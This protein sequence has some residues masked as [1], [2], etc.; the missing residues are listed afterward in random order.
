MK[1]DEHMLLWSKAAVRILDIRYKV[2][3]EGQDMLSYRL[4]ANVFLLV[5]SGSAYVQIDE[6]KT[7]LKRYHLLHAGKGMYVDVMPAKHEFAC[8]LVFYKAV[9]PSTS[10]NSA[11][12]RLAEQDR[13]FG[14]FFHVIP[15]EPAM[16]YNQIRRMYEGWQQSGVLA[17]IRM[18]AMLFEFIYELFT[19]LETSKEM[20]S[21]SDLVTHAL[22]YIHEHYTKPVT[23]VQLA[24]LLGCSISYMHRLFKAE[25]GKS[26]NEYII[27]KRMEQAQQ[28]L[29]TTQLN[30]REIAESVG[31]SDV[32]Y[33]SRLYKK[34]FGISPLQARKFQSENGFSDVN[35]LNPSRSS[36]VPSLPHSYNHDVNENHFH[37]KGEVDLISNRNTKPSMTALLVL[38]LS[39]LMSACQSGGNSISS[40]NQGNHTSNAVNQAAANS[41]AK[42][43][44]SAP[45]TRLYKHKYGE[46][47]IP[48]QPKRIITPYHLGHM[49]ALGER[50]LGA[51][52]YVLQY[53]ASAMD[54]TG[55]A[56]L[57]APLN[58]E[59]I[60]DLE[61][62]LIIIIEAYLEPSGG[63]EAFSKIAPTVVLEAHQD[64]IKDITLIGDILGKQ[65]EAQQWITQ[66]EAKIAE[67]KERVHQVI[68]P[69]ETF[70]ILNVRTAKNRMIYR[71]RNMG[72]NILYTY[73]GFK[74]QEK[75]LKDVI[76]GIDDE[77]SY[78]DIAEEAIPEYAGD[79]LILAAAADAQD[80][81]DELMKSGIWKNLDAV[82]NNHV[83][84]IDF[85]QFLF[86]DP[87]FSMK[88]ID[89]LTDLLTAGQ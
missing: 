83:Y 33:F 37:Q 1:W 47:E 18:K 15:P 89:I 86:N 9:L 56:D 53:S 35:P 51:A 24:D 21:P 20:G 82:K 8:Y 81:V 31:Y 43:G 46:T 36:I 73:W 58:L 72:G 10:P 14:K 80:S 78:L 57:G 75:V 66:F 27:G 3:W 48:V 88:Q 28:Y 71:D 67:T 70:T 76:E 52:T 32:Y 42:D 63:Y 2:M 25:V 79:H 77:S 40:E 87:I 55:I 69:E 62:D 29:L 23:M 12:K 6:N 64:P 59:A 16:L 61:P 34:Q 41:A 65:E 50:P 68:N 45:A 19:Q 26:P 49:L 60:S 44:E 85:D 17:Q 84:T 54:T 13:P 30:L 7:L 5:T 39:L 74:P 22:R 4:P 11:M 38:C